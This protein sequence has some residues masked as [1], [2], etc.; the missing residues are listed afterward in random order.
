MSLMTK[1]GT[2]GNT[3]L[4]G[5]VAIVTGGLS[6]IG[7]ATVEAFLA[8]GAAV[9]VSDITAPTST[10]N[11]DRLLFIRADVSCADDVESLVTKAVA[12]FGRVDVLVNNAGIGHL[13][14]SHEQ[15]LD[16]WRKTLSVNLDGCF[17]MAQ[18]VIRQMLMQP[19]ARDAQGSIQRGSIVNIASVHGLVGFPQHAAYT[20][21]KG[22]VIN[23]TRTLGIEYAQ[24]G[25][26]VNAVCPGF[27]LTPLI[28]A[29]VSAAMMPQVE[30]LHPIGRLGSAA[31]VA[32]P[33]VFLASDEASFITGAQLVVDGGYTAQ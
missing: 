17:L 9:V 32:A 3:R 30:S 31:E 19:A 1:S 14:P 7:A 11:D 22:A 18:A 5:K 25:I 4:A 28:V 21:S 24:Q 2:C 10:S 16:G 29:G 6:G 12:A 15:N 20:A 27:I 13:V 26:R 33:I 8:Q 23:L